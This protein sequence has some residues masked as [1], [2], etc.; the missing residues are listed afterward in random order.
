M[1]RKMMHRPWI[2]RRALSRPRRGR[3]PRQAPRLT[4]TATRELRRCLCWWIQDGMD[5]GGP[6][7]RQLE[8]WFDRPIWMPGLRS[9]AQRWPARWMADACGG[10]HIVDHGAVFSRR[11]VGQWTCTQR[12]LRQRQISLDGLGVRAW[13]NPPSLCVTGSLT[14]GEREGGCPVARVRL[15]MRQLWRMERPWVR[16]GQHAE[17]QGSHGERR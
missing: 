8:R 11:I 6:R 7:G 14:R 5:S 3:R 17:S 1:L 16:R 10:T 12:F 4:T 2:R 13:L 9:G 15:V